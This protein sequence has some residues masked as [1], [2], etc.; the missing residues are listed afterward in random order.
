[1]IAD[2]V[3]GLLKLG[4]PPGWVAATAGV[5]FRPAGLG[6][7]G[8]DGLNAI[9]EPPIGLAAGIG[10]AATP[11]PG[12]LKPAGLGSAGLDGRQSMPEREPG[13]AGTVVRCEAGSGV[14]ADGL[15]CCMFDANCAPAGVEAAG[16]AGL[17]EGFH[18]LP[19]SKTV[20][21]CGPLAPTVWLI[22]TRG[23]LLLLAS[24]I[25]AA[26]PVLP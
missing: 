11:A 14:K 21:R 6:S 12:M 3:C 20:G 7:G 17:A 22:G 8:L 4:A 10:A 24:A 2:R 9:P 13:V 18:G 1:M 23:V 25:P 16:R 19:F 5:G 15:C 26:P